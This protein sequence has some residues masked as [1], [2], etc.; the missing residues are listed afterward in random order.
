MSGKHVIGIISDSHG[1]LWPMVT[2]VFG[3]VELIIHA[4]DV[5]NEQVLE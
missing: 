1:L 2:G 4:G 5:G 3:E